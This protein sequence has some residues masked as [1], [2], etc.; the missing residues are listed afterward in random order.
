MKRTFEIECTEILL[1]LWYFNMVKDLYKNENCPKYGH[2][3]DAR[4]Y[5]P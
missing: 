4:Q 5:K 2:I 3:E 1:I